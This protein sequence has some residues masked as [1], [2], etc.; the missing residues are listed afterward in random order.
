VIAA[1]LSHTHAFYTSLFY[2]ACG[3]TQ[4]LLPRFERAAYLA[5]CE[6]FGSDMLTGVPAM[7][8][9]LLRDPALEQ[10][11][12]L[13][14]R[15]I[16]MGGSPISARLWDDVLGA[17]PNASILNVYGATEAGPLIFGPDPAG[18]AIPAC[19]CGWPVAGV[20]V[21]LVDER[22]ADAE[23]G[24]LWVRAP[25]G[26][27]RH[28]N[29][30]G[31]FVTSDRFR[32]DALGAYHFVGRTDD[33][34]DCGGVIVYPQQVEALLERHPDIREAVVVAVP[35]D[36]KTFV[37]VA[38]VVAR[39]PARLTEEAVRKFSL[40]HGPAYQHP[41]RVVFLDAFPLIGANKI[42]R[43]ALRKRAAGLARGSRV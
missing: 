26:S 23:E 35:D 30:D 1:P 11:D 12:R 15:S 32:R 19:A 3:S 33:A 4:I 16:R 13:R 10:I 14:I 5:A 28:R 17:F 2:L 40:E 24:T 27:L 36:V 42:D 8:A 34:F 18:R 21:R 38:F 43:L 6:Q 41:R 39:E 29:A 25:S 20:D 7:F 9:M 37:P 22:G 31:W